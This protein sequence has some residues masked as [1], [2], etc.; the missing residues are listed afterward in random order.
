MSSP[1][2]F[3]SRKAI[4]VRSSCQG[5]YT[6]THTYTLNVCVGERV[7]MNQWTKYIHKSFIHIRSCHTNTQTLNVK[8]FLEDVNPV[9]TR[10]VANAQTLLFCTI[11]TSSN[12]GLHLAFV[13]A[14]NEKMS[15]WERFIHG[16]RT[17][18]MTVNVR[19][20]KENGPPPS[21]FPSPSFSFPSLA[22]GGAI[23]AKMAANS[24]PN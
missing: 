12:T 22:F 23:Q 1:S 21:L 6:H 16:H 18:A 7:E 5:H 11:S 15:H 10:R 8:D 3:S 9:D 4:T 13:H 17:S 24:P 20:L 14:N 2:S 19:E